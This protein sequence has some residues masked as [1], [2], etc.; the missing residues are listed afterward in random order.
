M[1]NTFWYFY[2]EGNVIPFVK[3]L[4]GKNE[5][6]ENLVSVEHCL[7]NSFVIL[8][9]SWSEVDGLSA[10]FDGEIQNGAL[11]TGQPLLGVLN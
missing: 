4:D 6:W 2:T 5:E 3:G 8:S 11:W 7:E 10:S 1:S 9:G